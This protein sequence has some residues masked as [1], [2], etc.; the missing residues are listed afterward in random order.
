LIAKPK[1]LPKEAPQPTSGDPAD[2][3]PSSPSID[4]LKIGLELARLGK[5]KPIQVLTRAT[6]GSDYPFLKGRGIENSIEKLGVEVHNQYILSF[7]QRGNASGLHQIEV[8]VPDHG[9]L[10]IRSRRTYWAD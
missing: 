3:T 9:D 6:G 10:Q 5:T 4:Y 1:D 7:P 2:W 8:S